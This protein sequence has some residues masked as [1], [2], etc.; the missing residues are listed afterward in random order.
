M[1]ELYSRDN[2]RSLRSSKVYK[3]WGG[4]TKQLQKEGLWNHKV[5]GKSW[6]IQGFSWSEKPAAEGYPDRCCHWAARQAIG[7][8]FLSHLCLKVK[9]DWP[10]HIQHEIKTTTKTKQRAPT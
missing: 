2:F 6:W 1:R 4:N 5:V 7:P 8:C 9:P 10:H 3:N